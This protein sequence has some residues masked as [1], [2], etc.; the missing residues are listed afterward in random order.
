MKL[1]PFNCVVF[2]TKSSA[3]VT[4]KEV[5]PE[6]LNFSTSI[7]Q[8]MAAFIILAESAAGAEEEALERY[9]SY[10]DKFEYDRIS[11]LSCSLRSEKILDLLEG[12]ALELALKKLE[13]FEVLDA[14][15]IT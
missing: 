15:V 1:K 9:N 10:P 8:D 7:D 14:D 12:N 3:S 13:V 5:S 11:V 4:V 6:T 2:A